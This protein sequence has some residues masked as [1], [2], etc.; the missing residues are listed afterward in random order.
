[1]RA[2]GAFNHE[3]SLLDIQVGMNPSV[4]QVIEGHSGFDFAIAKC[5]VLLFATGNQFSLSL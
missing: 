5:V 3:P 4:H 1:M 2:F